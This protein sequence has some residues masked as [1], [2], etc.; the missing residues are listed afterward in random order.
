M[1]APALKQHPQSD[2]HVCRPRQVF[3][4]SAVQL[5]RCNVTAGLQRNLYVHQ[6][7]F[8]MHLQEDGV[9]AQ[10]HSPGEAAQVAL[11]APRLH[12]RLPMACV[13]TIYLHLPVMGAAKISSR[14]ALSRKSATGARI[15]QLKLQKAHHLSV[16]WPPAAAAARPQ[17]K[18]A[19]TARSCHQGA[20]AAPA[21]S[22]AVVLQKFNLQTPPQDPHFARHTLTLSQSCVDQRDLHCKFRHWQ[23]CYLCV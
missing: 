21:K 11:H 9:A 4:Q 23:S 2:C 10:Q 14:D 15:V 7:W 13:Q 8:E 20:V 3:C 12:E 6:H 17:P 5:L 16:V 22:P 1:S 19:G 18:T